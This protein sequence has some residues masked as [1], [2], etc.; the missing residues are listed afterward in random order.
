M[1]SRNNQFVFIIVQTL[2]I[3]WWFV[4]VPETAKAVNFTN[5]PTY[6]GQEIVNWP[7]AAGYDELVSVLTWSHKALIERCNVVHYS[8]NGLGPPSGYTR[9]PKDDIQLFKNIIK[10]LTH[11]FVDQSMVDDNGNFDS[12]FSTP[13]FSSFYQP[14]GQWTNYPHMFPMIADSMTTNMGLFTKLALP[15]NCLDYTPSRCLAGYGP[16]TTDPFVGHGHGWTNATTANGGTATLPDGRS[17]WYTTDYGCDA[18]KSLLSWMTWTSIQ[19]YTL[20]VATNDQALWPGDRDRLE[21]TNTDDSWSALEEGL[22]SMWLH[23]WNFETNLLTW[24]DPELGVQIY[25]NDFGPTPPYYWIF[26]GYGRARLFKYSYSISAN[27]SNLAHSAEIYSYWYGNP[28]NF[29][30]FPGESDH[31][32]RFRYWF[33]VEGGG[34]GCTQGVSEVL[35]ATLV[36]PRTEPRTWDDDGS[37]NVNY[38]ANFETSPWTLLKWDVSDGFKFK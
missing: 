38:E 30:S 31:Q 9:L 6:M 1:N 21:V 2:L 26:M 3:A 22:E 36:L 7:T 29:H 13:V 37:G 17:K 23:G 10:N 34:V 18:M 25:G 27:V 14:G 15:T 32:Q 19:G 20:I 4:M 8:T 33:D 12:W 5:W 24:P 11:S 28:I 35:N 16:F